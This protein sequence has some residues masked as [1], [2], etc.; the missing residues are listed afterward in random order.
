MFKVGDVLEHRSVTRNGFLL[1]GI[2]EKKTEDGFL[3]RIQEEIHN[4]EHISLR[5]Q[6]SQLDVE[7][8][9]AY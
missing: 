7:W 6:K 8:K 2:I 4:A 3:L 1:L 5:Y 9:Y